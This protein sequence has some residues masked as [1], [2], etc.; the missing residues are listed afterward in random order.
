VGG[1]IGL[2]LTLQVRWRLSRA[3]AVPEQSP[4]R[5]HRPVLSP[6]AQGAMREW[7]VTSARKRCSGS[8][9][10]ALG[11]RRWSLGLPWVGA[12]CDLIRCRSAGRPPTSMVSRSQTCI[13]TEVRETERAISDRPSRH[14]RDWCDVEPWPALPNAPASIMKSGGVITHWLWPGTRERAEA[15][16]RPQLGL[17]P[18]AFGGSG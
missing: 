3:K 8:A 14:G 7:G 9:R 1:G 17:R 10:V 18:P 15:L 13:T 6:L 12:G 16:L 11:A 4:S 5:S 2:E